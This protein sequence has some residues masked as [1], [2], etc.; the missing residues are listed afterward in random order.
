MDVQHN[1]GNTQSHRASLL[2]R[3][4]GQ[5]LLPSLK[6]AATFLSRF[7]G[8][9][10]QKPL[11]KEEGLLIVPCRSIHTHWMRFS[12]DIA[13]ID[14][15]GFVLDVNKNVRPW[16]IAQGP[17]N[18]EAVIETTAQAVDLE[19]GQNVLISMPNSRGQ[20]S[21]N[22]SLSKLSQILVSH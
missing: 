8:L 6:I 10:F 12:I 1:S 14:A 4:S 22:R 2:D 16:K 17:P 9:Q 7:R 18:A 20:L 3:E 21:L 19:T 13:W 11:S 5:V 15:A